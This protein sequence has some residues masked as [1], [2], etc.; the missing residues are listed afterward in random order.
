MRFQ[1]LGRKRTD[2]SMVEVPIADDIISEPTESFICVILRPRGEDG[3]VV[4]DPNTLTVIIEDDDCEYVY[5]IHVH[6]LAYIRLF[7][8]GIPNKCHYVRFVVC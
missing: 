2:S 7:C 3:I 1:A 4:G 8:W 5:R 6:T